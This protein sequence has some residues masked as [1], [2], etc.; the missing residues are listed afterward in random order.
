MLINIYS[1]LLIFTGTKWISLSLNLLSH[2]ICSTLLMTEL[3]E[4]VG[5]E[6][7]EVFTSLVFK[8]SSLNH[9]DTS[10][11]NSSFYLFI[12]LFYKDLP[13]HGLSYFT[14]KPRRTT[15][16][17][18]CL[19]DPSAFYVYADLSTYMHDLC[20]LTNSPEKPNNQ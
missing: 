7:T 4:R 16:I 6:P 13:L 11:Y 19:C 17:Y 10:P 14:A 12:E 8:T 9:S 18:R 2:I 5:F 3:A 20:W 1:I 15:F